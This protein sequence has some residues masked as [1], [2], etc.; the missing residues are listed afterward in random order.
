MK[1]QTSQAHPLHVRNEG[2]F[3]LNTRIQGTCLQTPR[4]SNATRFWWVSTQLSCRT[5]CIHVM[6]LAAPWPNVRMPLKVESVT[7][8]L[9]SIKYALR[10]AN[11]RGETS[12]LDGGQW[13]ASRPQ[14]LYPGEV[15][16]GTY[17]TWGWMGP[18]VSLDVSGERTILHLLG[19]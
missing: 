18:R 7:L 9:C 4:T 5:K 2:C 12:E 8:A 13:S 14:P 10:H 15:T 17:W 3:H 6:S 1:S 19:T 16:N 11:V